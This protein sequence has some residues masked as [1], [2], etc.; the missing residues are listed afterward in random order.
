MKRFQTGLFRRIVFLYMIQALVLSVTGIVDCTVVG[1]FIGAEGL[2]G[3]KLAMPVFSLQY[4]FGGIFS[5][6][7]TVQISKYLTK[8]R[9]DS[10]NQCF[11]WACAA[12]GAVSLVFM[13]AAGVFPEAVTG[14]FAAHTEDIALY[15]NTKAYLLP[16][17]FGCMPVM[18]QIILSGTAALEGEDRRLTVSI[19]AVLVS[20]I[21]GDFAAVALGAGIRGIAIASVFAYLCACLVLAGHLFSGKS[22]FRPARLIMHDGILTALIISG[23]PAAVKWFCEFLFPMAVNRIMLRYGSVSGLAALS[24]QDAAHYIPLSLSDGISSAVILLTSMYAAEY[25][26]EALRR[27]R[28]DFLRFSVADGALWAVILAL[29]SP[30]LVKL[31]SEEPMLQNMGVSAFRWYLLGVPFLCLNAAAA[32]YMQGMGRQKDAGVILLINRLVLP[33]AFSWFLG[34]RAG[35]PGI[36]A[37]FAVSEIVFALILICMQISGKKKHVAYGDDSWEKADVEIRHDL[38]TLEQVAE[39]SDEVIQIC[40]KNGVDRKQAFYVGLCLEELA[41][42]SL[43]HGYRDNRKK[44]LEYRLVITGDRLI[45][46]L[47][48]NGCAFDLTE[49]YKLLDPDDPVSGIGLRLVYAAAEDVAYSHVFDL[50]NVCIRIRHA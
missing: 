3:M 22:I 15:E 35:A 19:A 20:D 39:A 2:A 30:L 41:A 13:L 34:A 7:L 21:I 23:L 47:R 17:L 5:T 44:Y 45:L 1:R 25:D 49:K 50:N 26:K 32:S 24:I 10:A 48:D 42:N 11:L 16:V 33:V 37:S 28:K 14:I 36:F 31:F 46:R 9:R 12:T 43:M 4:L 6:G 29:L 40:K 8:G 27:E 38:G 18:M